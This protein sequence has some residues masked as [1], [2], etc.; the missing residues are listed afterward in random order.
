MKD[1]QDGVA[2]TRKQ[3][4]LRLRD[5][6]DKLGQIEAEVSDMEEVIQDPSFA[7][8]HHHAHRRLA[9]ARRAQETFKELVAIDME[10]LN[11]HDDK[12]E[13]EEALAA[14]DD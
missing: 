4:L 12:Q 9:L 13:V 3:N 2:Y 11:L 10:I 6:L 5:H 7:E 14:L 8:Q 1:D